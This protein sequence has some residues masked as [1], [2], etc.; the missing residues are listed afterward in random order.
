MNRLKRYSG[1]IWI[2]LGPAALL[3]LVKGVTSLLSNANKVITLATGET[4]RAAAV[5]ARNNLLLQWGILITIFVPIIIGLVIFGR[6]ALRGEYD[7]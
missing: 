3:L 6:Y 2:L 7:K 1:I 4:A 5:A